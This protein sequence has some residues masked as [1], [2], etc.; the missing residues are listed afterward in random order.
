MNSTINK[1]LAALGVALA[2]LFAFV[3]HSSA[4]AAPASAPPGRGCRCAGSIRTRVRGRC[5]AARAVSARRPSSASSRCTISHRSKSSYGF[6]RVRAIPALHAAEV[7]RRRDAAARAARDAPSRS[8][9]PLR[10]AARAAAARASMP[11]DP[12]LRTIDPIDA[13]C[14]TSGSSPPRTSITR[15]TLARRARRSWSG[16]S[17]PAST[18]SPTSAGKVDGLWTSTSSA[19][20]H[21]GRASRGNDD[22]GH[23]TAVASLIAANVDDGFGMAGFGGATHVIAVHAGSHG[24]L[25][26]TDGRDRAR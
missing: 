13:A 3:P 14:P 25:H 4:A 22:D 18:T 17:T 6:E 21:V 20:R 11:N 19:T 12:L 24:T 1:H 5:R 23:G 15:S 9:H 10:L 26:R 2:A 8:A 7:T 16:S